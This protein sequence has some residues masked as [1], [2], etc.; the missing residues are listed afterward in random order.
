M[1]V[2]FPERVSLA[3]RETPLQLLDGL[4]KQLGKRV[5]VWRDDMTG[6]ELSGNKVRKLEFLCGEAAT[7]GADHL[8]TCGAVQSNHARATAFAARRM[9]WDVTLV[10]REPPGGLDHGAPA[11]GNL[12]LDTIAGTH[13]VTISAET[14]QAHGHS[15]DS[16][17]HKASS[18]LRDQ[19]ASPYII[20]LGGSCP[21]GCWGYLAAMELLP[22]KLNN[23]PFDVFCAVGSGGTFAGLE[24]GCASFSHASRVHGVNVSDT[25]DYFDSEIRK[26]IAEFMD[27]YATQGVE[28]E[29]RPLNIYDGF[30][31]DGYG[32]ASDDDLRF[33]ASLARKTGMLLDP[34]YTGKAFRGMLH[35][36]QTRPDDFYDDI[37]FLH[38]GGQHATFAF[39]EQYHRALS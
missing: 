36:L 34:V 19:G 27:M 11:S 33:Y 14:Y 5:H 30:V 7:Q 24:L 1:A 13:N 22:G 6:W 32:I 37:V 31:G 21:L 28:Y 15:F 20:P 2:E 18:D 9:G 10:M 26:L 39:A 12:L 38:S 35:Q 4:S 16:F 17:L 8:L 23:A 25:A 29:P 3:N